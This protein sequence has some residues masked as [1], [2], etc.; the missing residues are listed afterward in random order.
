MCKERLQR[1]TGLGVWVIIAVAVVCAGCRD[2]ADSARRVGAGEPA[3]VS[4]GHAS[5]D[6]AGGVTLTLDTPFEVLTRDAAGSPWR[7]L[8]GIGTDGGSVRIPACE[9]WCA[10]IGT[11]EG[12]RLSD[13]TAEALQVAGVTHL[14]LGRHEWVGDWTLKRVSRLKRLRGLR[15]YGG[16]ALTDEG[17]AYLK[18]LPRLRVLDVYLDDEVTQRGM[19]HLGAL[20]GLRHLRLETGYLTAG[21]LRQLKGLTGLRR[22][23]LLASPSREAKETW[24]G[25]ELEPLSA[26]KHLRHLCLP[27]AL[28]GD[29][30]LRPLSGCA[31]LETL[32]IT[33]NARGHTSTP[34]TLIGADGVAA[35]RRLG[36]LRSLRLDECRIAGAARHAFESLSL[37][38]LRLV[39]CTI[40]PSTLAAVGHMRTLRKLSLEGTSVTDAQL[41]HLKP[42]GQLRW[43]DLSKCNALTGAGLSHLKEMSGLRTLWLDDCTEL[44][45]AAMAHAVELSGLRRISVRDCDGLTDAGFAH[46]SNMNGLREIY[47]SDCDGL[48]D[49]GLAQVARVSTLHTM[50]IVDCAR[51]T[52]VGLIPLASMDSLE[53]LA[54]GG[55][56][57]PSL[58]DLGHL[59]ATPRRLRKLRV[60]RAEL[61]ERAVATLED[62]P[63]VRELMLWCCKITDA[64]LVHFYGLRRLRIIDL[65]LSSEVTPTGLTALC[66]ALPDCAVRISQP[67]PPY[68]WD[69]H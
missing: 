43:L 1:L 35:L 25:S 68:A 31:S 33:S 57:G 6:P 37:R 2:A 32:A 29:A 46:V 56:A 11:V 27:R 23:D 60:D 26:M 9:A 41:V 44:A 59:E 34:A 24:T 54:I 39:R 8:A 18:S 64:Q 50:H 52:A 14:V 28:L 58:E 55:K 65:E 21:K 69:S 42:L 47:L 3:A 61:S 12:S 5:S 67:F 36:Q 30:G 17:M 49:V 66:R 63:A 7:Y 10:C 19:A 13:A 20:S 48:S 4:R 53:T 40:S 16:D 45:D 51:L 38:E 22:L 62:L 15:F